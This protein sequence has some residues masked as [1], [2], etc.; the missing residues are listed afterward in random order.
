[1]HEK[2]PSI[3]EIYCSLEKGTVGSL[4]FLFGE[5]D[6]LIDECVDAIID[7][8]IPKGLRAFNVDIVDSDKATANDIVSFATAYPMMTDRRVVVARE[9]HKMT[10]T[11]R[12]RDIF[13]SYVKNPLATTCFIMVSDK[14][15]DFRLK[16]FSELKRLN[17]VYEFPRFYERQVPSWIEKRCRS[18]GKTIEPAAIELLCSVVGTSLRSLNN[19]IIKIVTYIGE[20]EV[21][22]AED[23]SK[24]VGAIRGSTIFDLQ[25]AIGMRDSTTAFAILKR[26]LD[27]SESPQGIIVMLTRYILHLMRVKELLLKGTPESVIAKEINVYQFFVKDYIDAATRIS[28]AELEYSVRVLCEIDLLLKTTTIENSHAMKML[29]YKLLKPQETIHPMFHLL[30]L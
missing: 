29:L 7:S 13:L 5:E 30:D 26:M 22:C 27:A 19:E 2:F 11:E 17:C 21:V 28:F 15:P 24:V 23:V 1:M 10:N 18:F 4:Y 12:E 14:K 8:L 3:E 20:R 9:F 16:L 25:R 6:F